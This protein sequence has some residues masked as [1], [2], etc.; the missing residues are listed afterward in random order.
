MRLNTTKAI[1]LS[2]VALFLISASGF[3]QT[4][5]KDF[6][7]GQLFVKFNDNYDPQI[8]VAADK[9]VNMTD[10]SYFQDIFE[11][12]DVESMSRPLDDFND[13]KLLKTFL[14]SFKDYYVLDEVIEMLEAKPEIEYAEKV[15]IYYIEYSPNDS[16]YNLVNGP[17]NWNWH[18][19]VI[20]A[21]QAWDVTKGSE[22]IVVA[23]V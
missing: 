12:Y 11:S 7:D 23:I 19:D 17:S 2:I 3:A 9:S 1:L 22:D 10:A 14:L 21:E 20:D 18:L 13:P 6:Q 5:E 16:L 4:F 8:S 15:N